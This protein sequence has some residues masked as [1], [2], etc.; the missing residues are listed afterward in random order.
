MSER[1]R[2]RILLLEPNRYRAI[3][4]ERTLNKY[5]GLPVLARCETGD[6]ALK[7]LRANTY[8]VAIFNFD[9]IRTDAVGFIRQARATNSDLLM[10]GLARP[11]TP[12]TVAAAIR[13]W[14]DDYL[15]WQDPIGGHLPGAI[16]KA[17][18]QLLDKCKPANVA[19]VDYFEVV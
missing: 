3:L 13:R 2:L 16:G 15:V 11:E 4:I 1:P 18:D 6:I 19:G 10:I 9:G 14:G 5:F 8:Q 17:V 12:R 7:E